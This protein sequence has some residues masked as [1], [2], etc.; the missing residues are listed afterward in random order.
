ML[1]S[2]L[3][4]R[5]IPYS[6]GPGFEDAPD[7]RPF[8][9]L[10]KVAFGGSDQRIEELA[11]VMAAAV[12]NLPAGSLSMAISIEAAELIEVFHWHGNLPSEAYHDEI[13]IEEN[14]EEELADILLYSLSLAAEFDISLLEAVGNK[15]EANETR[16]DEDTTGD[17]QVELQRWQTD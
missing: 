13:S 14:V 3:E 9:R 7:I 6:G 8:L 12:M 2:A 4:A 1:E 11:P 17:I 10:L 5:D 16:F 15:L